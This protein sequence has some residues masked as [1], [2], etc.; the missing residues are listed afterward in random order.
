MGESLAG[1]FVLETLLR[2]P[3]LFDHYVAFDPSLWWDRG[4]LVDSARAGLAM[5]GT[6]RRTLFVAQSRDDRDDVTAR[7]GALLRTARPVG[8]RWTHVSRPEL[9]HATVF[10]AMKPTALVDALR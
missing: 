4:V 2:E 1:L 8:L 9:T 5:P 10:R 6:K 7:L 3:T